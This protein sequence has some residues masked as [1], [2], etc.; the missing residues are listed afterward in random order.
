MFRPAGTN[1]YMQF[2]R[3]AVQTWM[4]TDAW[5]VCHSPVIGLA[6]Q[7]YAPWCCV[8]AVDCLDKAVVQR[9]LQFY[10]VVRL[11]ASPGPVGNIV[12]RLV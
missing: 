6:E 5:R 10:I 1:L 3:Y 2:R 9:S 12:G 8:F 7:R 4:G 11:S